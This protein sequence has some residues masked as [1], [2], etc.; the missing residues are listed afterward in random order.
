MTR[1]C[2][3]CV[4]VR[5]SCFISL[6]VR[7]YTCVSRR[8]KNSDVSYTSGRERYDGITLGYKK[9]PNERPAGT[10]TDDRRKTTR[11]RR[12]TTTVVARADGSSDSASRRLGRL[13]SSPIASRVSVGRRRVVNRAPCRRRRDGE[14]T[15]AT[16]A[17][18]ETTD[19]DARGRE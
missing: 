15:T 13:A 3:V 19:E 8:G 6:F 14:T 10:T 17:S 5:S 4:Y 1:G 9:S 2:V 11:G 12:T 16:R 18:D 7:L